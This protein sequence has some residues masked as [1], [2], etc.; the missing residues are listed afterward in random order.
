MQ[1]RNSRG[2][3]PLGLP[4]LV[5]QDRWAGPGV[6]TTTVGDYYQVNLFH[7]S[8]PP[9]SRAMFDNVY[10]GPISVEIST[11][12]PSGRLCFKRFNSAG[13]KEQVVYTMTV[14]RTREDN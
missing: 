9:L 7:V 3:K 1:S 5:Y 11:A 14:L 12:N 13:K 8:D 4:N 2:F 6:F 10:L